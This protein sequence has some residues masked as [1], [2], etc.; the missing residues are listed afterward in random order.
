M[1]YDS[2]SFKYA[3]FYDLIEYSDMQKQYYFEGIHKDSLQYVFL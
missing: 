3:F 2:V 1:Q